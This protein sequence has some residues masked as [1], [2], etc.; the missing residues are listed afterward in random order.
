MARRS[1]RAARNL[2]AAGG[3]AAKF[4]GRATEKAAV[5]LFRWATTD[6]YG[7]GDAFDR[8]AG[9]GFFEGLKH[10]KLVDGFQCR[11]S[12]YVPPVAPGRKAGA[13]CPA[14]TAYGA[15][16]IPGVIPPNTELTFEIELLGIQR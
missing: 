7:T 4:A 10:N 1:N 14:A 2:R 13:T 5:G 9:M 11:I 12:G 6:H 8:A 16:G 3:D 15:R